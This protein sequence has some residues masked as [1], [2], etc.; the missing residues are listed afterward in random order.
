MFI[1]HASIRKLFILKRLFGRP[2]YRVREY[3]INGDHRLFSVP[4]SSVSEFRY[5]VVP[6]R[7]PL[8]KTPN[9]PFTIPDTPSPP[10]TP[11]VPSPIPGPP[12]YQLTPTTPA[13]DIFHTP[14]PIPSSIDNMTS[15]SPDVPL[16][17][18]PGPPPSDKH[19]WV[20]E[21]GIYVIPPEQRRSPSPIPS[22]GAE[23]PV[24][25]DSQGSRPGSPPPRAGSPQATGADRMHPEDRSSIVS[26]IVDGLTAAFAVFW[27]K[28]PQGNSVPPPVQPVQPT[29]QQPQS[30]HHRDLH[31]YQPPR[32][33]KPQPDPEPQD[34]STYGQYYVPKY[35]KDVKVCKPPFFTG[36]PKGA[37]FEVFELAI[38]E[39]LFANR[40]A[41]KHDTDKITFVLSYMRNEDG[42]STPAFKWKKNWM[43]RFAMEDFFLKTF[44]EFMEDLDKTF[45][46][47]NVLEL[48]YQR[49]VNTHM[50]GDFEEF[51]TNFEIDANES[52]YTIPLEGE[53]GP[54]DLFLIQ[55]LRSVVH[56]SMIKKMYNTTQKVPRTYH[57]FKDALRQGDIN[58]KLMKSTPSTT[59]AP[60]QT[61]APKPVANQ[62]PHGMSAT[63]PGTT[64]PMDTTQRR[65]PPTCFNCGKTPE[66]GRRWHMSK[67]CTLPCQFCK[68]RHPGK[69]CS[70]RSP[71]A[72]TVNTR[73]TDTEARAEDSAASTGF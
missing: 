45:A 34:P 7:I 32:H 10:Q 62:N 53:T 49:L 71:R 42:T 70:N 44:S 55:I 57:G 51:I 4:R 40:H 15:P 26:A 8:P 3:N 59:S 33:P 30:R 41:Y 2:A 46:D 23:M 61:A 73:A 28:A 72:D 47:K 6:T 66:P 65:G 54:Y 50:K 24:G 64:G 63:I 48:A 9:Q 18:P 39:Y 43:K 58:F 5:E 56:P 68:G 20:P 13:T 38:R 25:Q 11:S 36:T 21:M 22:E 60:K 29:P 19:V 31:N 52:G 27:G 37:S 12:H 69:P 17:R 67:D 14:S 35:D 16:A 1:R